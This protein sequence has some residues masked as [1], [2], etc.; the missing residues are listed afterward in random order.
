MER[1]R[2]FVP[3]KINAVQERRS[4]GRSSVQHC[5][6]VRET[7]D[8]FQAGAW[9]VFPGLLEMFASTDDML[10]CLFFSANAT[11]WVAPVQLPPPALDQEAAHS[12]LKKQGA[13][14]ISLV[15]AGLF[16]SCAFERAR[17][18]FSSGSPSATAGLR[19]VSPIC[20]SFRPILSSWQP[21]TWPYLH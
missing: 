16:H 9:G 20:E 4:L 8:P 6:R 17:G 14:S 7:Q 5:I 15:P 10:D 1:K 2:S 12:C 3:P 11:G 18:S 19:P 21:V 13:G